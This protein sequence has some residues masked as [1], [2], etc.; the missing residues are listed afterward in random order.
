MTKL[1]PRRFL[2]ST[3]LIPQSTY[4][5]KCWLLAIACQSGHLLGT[6]EEEQ[7]VITFFDENQ[8]KTNSEENVSEFSSYHFEIHEA[9]F[10][11]FSNQTAANES[12]KEKTEVIRKV[13]EEGEKVVSEGHPFD[14]IFL[15]ASKLFDTV[16]PQTVPESY[17]ADSLH[18]SQQ[19]AFNELA[20]SDFSQ[21]KEEN[22]ARANHKIEI[23]PSR[24]TEQQQEF[25]SHP[26][27]DFLAEEESIPLSTQSEESIP[28]IRNKE[29]ISSAQNETELFPEYDLEPIKHENEHVIHASVSTDF[30]QMAAE[31][32]TFYSEKEPHQR[33]TSLEDV[34][35]SPQTEYYPEYDLEPIDEDGQI[36]H[37]TIT[38]DFTHLPTEPFTFSNEN[39]PNGHN[40]LTEEELISKPVPLEEMD[41]SSYENSP[42]GEFDEDWL[43]DFPLSSIQIANKTSEE[44][45]KTDELTSNNS[46]DADFITK[47]EDQHVAVSEE[48]PSPKVLF[49]TN[50]REHALKNFFDTEE[51]A[52]PVKE[53][54]SDADMHAKHASQNDKPTDFYPIEKHD[55]YNVPMIK[56]ENSLEIPPTDANDHSL[57]PTLTPESQQIITPEE[58]SESLSLPSQESAPTIDAQTSTSEHTS[59]HTTD[60][61]EAKSIPHTSQKEQKF[62]KELVAASKTK[63]EDRSWSWN[64]AEDETPRIRQK[65]QTIKSNTTPIPEVE[66]KVSKSTLPTASHSAAD[67][68]H[69]KENILA[70]STAVDSKLP[71]VE[72][73]RTELQTPSNDTPTT[74]EGITPAGIESPSQSSPSA[75]PTPTP[76]APTLPVNDVRNQPHRMTVITPSDPVENVESEMTITPTTTTTTATTPIAPAAPKEISINFNNVSMIEYIRFISRISN[77]NFIFDDQDLQFNVTI[78][79]EE[80]TTIENLMAA[81]LQELRIRN[82]S[83]IE[84]GNNIIIHTNPRVRAP[85]HVEVEGLQN[86]SK[87]NELVTRVFRLNT[88]DPNKAGEIIRPLVSDDAL[89]EV[90]R[91]TNNLIITDFTVNINKIAQLINSLDAPHSGV[92]LGQYVVRNGFVDTLVDLAIK[93]LAPIAQ[94]NP[95]VLVPHDATN[96]IYVVS[97]GFIVEKALAI[98]ENLDL[99]EGKT[100]ILSLDKLHFI[101]PSNI[102]GVTGGGRTGTGASG[103]GVTGGGVSTGTGG[104]GPAP[105]EEFNIPGTPGYNP[106]LPAKYPFGVPGGISPEGGRPGIFAPEEFVPG[107][108]STHPNWVQGLPTGHIER[109]LF[110]IYKLKYRRGDQIEIALRKIGESLRQTGTANLDM[111]AA[112]NSSQ[113][114]EASNSLIFTG[115]YQALERIKELILE[116]DLPLRQVFIEM[117]ILDTSMT[118]SLKYGVDWGTRFGGGNTA[119]GQGFL[120]LGS[121]LASNLDAGI[122][123]A[124]P[125]ATTAATAIAAS[126]AIAHPTAT[127]LLNG[128]GYSAGIIGRHITHGGLHFNTIGALIQALYTDTNTNIIMSPK[129]ITEDNNPA[130]IFVGST[131]RYKTQSISN[132][133]GSVLTNNFQFLDVGSTFRVTPQI[134]NNGIITLDIIQENTNDNGAANTTS[135][136]PSSVDV[137]LVPVLNKSRTTTRIHVPDGFFVILSGMIQDTD[138]STVSRIPCLGGIPLIG[139]VSKQQGKSESKR[140]L[141]LFIRPLIVDSE[142][143]LENITKRQQDVIREK[144]K[145]RRT[146]NY[147]IDEAMDFFNL[148]STDPNDYCPVK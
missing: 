132:D 11:D 68:T 57:T 9:V 123:S 122:N 102:E 100:K 86:T 134:G 89:I 110:F 145:L 106:N 30:S 115:T 41:L 5:L 99:N 59:V 74:E 84:Q 64:S 109:T 141:M 50:N 121:N 10:S 143:E 65:T 120:G 3:F 103:T 71:E 80:P 1:S 79:S 129:I 14:K 113:W 16:K 69:S 36:I 96:S 8:S 18:T 148:K 101:E 130:E 128:T 137:N 46:M 33:L 95:Y 104:I 34:E 72:T 98:L 32:L 118:D 85:A 138:T 26:I 81:L 47:S 35:N 39:Q 105:E 131:Q 111:I 107:G 4:L 17:A 97:N 142:E 114:I 133:R 13:S 75:L 125:L 44:E 76:S 19:I 6:A 60:E 55:A 116:V 66:D 43:A 37:A 61:F 93:I 146:W 51:T 29:E 28:S 24:E 119:G 40:L 15:L 23:E 49:F 73:P 21:W 108:I 127:A 22:E 92:T 83:L 7:N 135:N 62:S 58:E 25:H 94:G 52:S 140:N 82:L 54:L 124:T 27:Q 56:D 12:H 70:Q 67:L 147:E 144:N 20:Y 77:K 87:E 88:L 53:D 42:L 38:S 78:V 91:D 63:F 45:Y 126:A 112:I 31:P 90:L 117:L 136:N 2:S 48:P 139:A